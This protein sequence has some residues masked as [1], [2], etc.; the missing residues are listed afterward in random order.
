M[1]FVLLHA[2]TTARH[3][4]GRSGQAVQ[5]SGS[6]RPMVAR[7]DYTRKGLA[8]SLTMLLLY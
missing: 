5:R 4:L 2:L 6:S 8:S 1:V 7:L 3:I